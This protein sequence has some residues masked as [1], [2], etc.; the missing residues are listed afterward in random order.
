MK[1]LIDSKYIDVDIL[2]IRVAAGYESSDHHSA[3]HYSLGTQWSKHSQWGWTQYLC[4]SSS[5]PSLLGVSTSLGITLY[6]TLAGIHIA[7]PW[8]VRMSLFGPCVVFP[9][10]RRQEGDA[11]N[12]HVMKS[13]RFLV[14]SLS[15][16]LKATLMKTLWW[17]NAIYSNY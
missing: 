12:V 1:H 17:I 7:G 10:E 8:V 11:V 14:S 9:L 4:L 13:S 16:V 2:L 15:R 6:E 5:S 3:L